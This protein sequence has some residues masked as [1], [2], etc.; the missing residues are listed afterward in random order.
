MPKSL[1]ERQNSVKYIYNCILRIYLLYALQQ[2][3]SQTSYLKGKIP[4]HCTHC[5]LKSKYAQLLWHSD[6]LSAKHFFL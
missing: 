4:L 2:F 1:L 5:S 6:S 3:N